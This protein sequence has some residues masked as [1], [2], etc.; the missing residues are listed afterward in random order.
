MQQ[1]SFKSRAGK[2]ILLATTMASGMAFFDGSTTSVALPAIQHYFHASLSQLQWIVN[3]FALT[4]AS[5]LLLSGSLGDRFGRKKIFI[6]GIIVFIIASA[7]SALSH[8]TTQL[9]IYQ[10]F[11]GLGGAMMIPGSLAIINTSFAEES[12]GKVIGLWAGYSGGLA[13]LGPFLGGWLTQ[14]FGWPA[15][16][17]INVPL[18]LIALFIALS[19]VPE[20]KNPDAKKLDWLGAILLAAGLLGLSWGLISAP[21]LGWSNTGVI[22]GLAG[23]IVALLLFAWQQK[24]SSK[25]L[26]PLQ[27]F[28]SPLVAGANL[29]TL[30]LYFALYG[31]IFFL[32]LNFQQVQGFS[33]LQAGLAM[34]PPIIIITF[35]T[36]PAGGLSDKIGPRTQM[37]LGPLLVSIGM[38][39]LIIPG[40]HAN[41]WTQFFPGQ[42]LFGLGM[43]LVIA[44]LTKS[45]LSVPHQYSGA[46]SGANNAISR[47]AAMLAVAILG[48]VI[49]TS[50][51]TQLA[52]RIASLDFSSQEQQQ[53]MSQANKLGGIEIPAGFDAAKQQQAQTNIRDSFVHSFRY[54][55]AI[56]ASLA[57]LAAIIAAFT[58]RNPRPELE[59][60]PA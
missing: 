52:G 11:Q 10:A 59:K 33:P 43:C 7:L 32:V 5:L 6:Y 58:I 2:L 54:A 24:R 40:T 20:S 26:V 21:R 19:Y 1:Y 46:A 34:L 38:A 27:I 14:T 17:W 35:L 4:L 23:G 12:R 56:T 22:T 45:A 31:L 57:L 36:G 49:I 25:P 41:Y 15:V 30:F 39:L 29:V 18:G 48:A 28:K 37:I 16:W 44:P 13:A 51:K 47:I 9:I 60:N 8:S 55:M 53:L 42:V 3:A 50:F